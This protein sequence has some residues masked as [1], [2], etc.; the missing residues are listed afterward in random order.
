MSKH[1]MSMT[2]A[3]KIDAVQDGRCTQTIRTMRKRKIEVGDSIRFHGWSGKAYRSKW[4]KP[5]CVT[6]T[7]VIYCFASAEGLQCNNTGIIP[8]DDILIDIIARDDFIDPPTGLA[9]RDVL[10][11]LNGTPTIPWRYQ[12]IRWK[13]DR[14]A[15]AKLRK[16]ASE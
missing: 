10:F 15:T 8:W 7:D 2:Y 6:V 13:I 11:K 16:E 12:I 4:N 9:L 14:E 1:V 3:P 5:M